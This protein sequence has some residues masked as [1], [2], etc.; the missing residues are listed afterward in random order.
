MLRLI[1]AAL[2]IS[3]LA[4]GAA[5]ASET[6]VTLGTGADALHGSLIEPD[7]AGAAA[8][9]V[10]GSGPTD[11]DGNS[12]LGISAS[13]YRLLAEAL[14]ERGVTTLRIDKRGIAASA[15]AGIPEPE[16]RFDTFVDDVRGW[17]ADIAVRT[18][19]PCVWVI[20][21]SEGALVGQAA[22]ADNP[23]VCGL[24]LMNAAG[25]PAADVIAEQLRAGL[26]EPML[27]QALHALAELNEGRTAEAPAQLAGLFRADIQPYLISWFRYDPAALIADWDRPVMI[28]HATHDIQVAVADADALAAAQPNAVRLDLEGVNHVLKVAPADRA[29]NIATYSNPD[30][31]LA[32]GVADAVAAF[33][34]GH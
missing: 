26:P 4:S 6:E 29:G 32:S 20:G 2:A 28:V 9:I 30:L 19:H 8:L 15:P 13:T 10:P 25:R 22:A 3:L 34:L 33:I 1:V 18:G 17:I 16:L 14:G 7:G 23:H 5:L 27:G 12:P 21:H 31:P 11:R 24:V